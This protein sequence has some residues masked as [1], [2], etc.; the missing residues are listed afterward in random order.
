MLQKIFF[1][2]GMKQLKYFNKLTDKEKLKIKV[3]AFFC[4][5]NILKI[6]HPFIHILVLVICNKI[7]I[8]II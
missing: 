7:K 8:D 1:V 5:N 4:F 2:I 3:C 6:T